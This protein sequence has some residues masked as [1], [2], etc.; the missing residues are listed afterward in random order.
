MKVKYRGFEIEAVRDWNMLYT[1]KF[2]FESC[3]RLSD[4]MDFSSGPYP[5]EMTVREVIADSKFGIDQL[6]DGDEEL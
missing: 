1:E 5:S 2:I 6:L 4:G 3:I